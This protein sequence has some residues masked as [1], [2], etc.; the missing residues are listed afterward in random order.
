[1][2]AALS[3]FL[4]GES[5][6]GVVTNKTTNKPAA[7]DDVVLIRLQQGMQEATR[8]KTDAHGRFTLDVPDE[9]IHLVRV[10]HDKANYFR[11]APPGT[12]SVEI[13][14][15]N[16]AA[17]VK[18][19]SGEADV[20]RIQT[21]ASGKTLHVVENFFVKNESSP[22]L[23]QFSDRPFEF[24]LPAGAVVEGSA[25]LAPGG[26]PVQASPV[27]LGDAN[28]YAFIFPIRPGETRFQITYRLP[29]SGSLKFSP[30]VGMPTD[31]IAVMMPKSMTFAG[32]AS[33]PYSPVT[34]ETTAQTYVA[35][36]VAPSEPLDFTVSGAGQMPRDTEAAATAG[37][38]GA[39]ASGGTGAAAGTAATDTR[40]GGGLG[41]PLDPEGTNDPWAK[42]KWWI[43]GGLGLVMAAGAGFMLTGNQ[44][45]VVAPAGGAVAIAGGPASLL[46][47]MK[48]ELFA[49]ETD[50]LQGRLTEKEYLEQKAALEVVL[51]RALLRGEG[52][53]DASNVAGP[54]A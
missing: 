38:G 1:M 45:G 18:G 42:Y 23:T 16:A 10:T 47:A 26:M 22:P 17:K 41:V 27:P 24:Y 37:Q 5:I 12:Q 46:G 40:P 44:K 15:Y 43:L 36:N 14:V 52:G 6:T 54:V 20:M 9:G 33:T 21:D 13:D 34:E 28:H 49:L 7:G 25:A 39:D 32:G 4:R 29:Y 48:E 50:K 51:R 19:V 30:R 2:V 53:P 11:P 3:G 31:T 8:T 35:R